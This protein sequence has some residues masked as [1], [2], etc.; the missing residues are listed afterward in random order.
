MSTP[1]TAVSAAGT[2][3]LP[4]RLWL[5]TGG[6]GGHVFPALALGVAA[7]E[8][9]WEVTVIGSQDGPEAGWTRD[10]GL[11][12]A[13]V[14]SG[15]LD[16]QRP[17]PRQL[18]RALRGV[19]AAVGL[20]RQAR[21]R[22]LVG[23]GGFAS[24]PGVAAARWLR[25]PYLLHETNAHPGLVTRWFAK[26]ARAVV[27]TQEVTA[28]A[29]PGARCLVLPLPVRER[30]PEPAAARAAFGLPE[31]ALVTLVMGGSQG[32]LYLN[33]TVPAVAEALQRERADLWVLHQTGHPW[34]ERV[35]QATDGRPRYL[36]LPFVDGSAAF[37]A[38]DMAITRAGYGTI[39]EAAF[40]RVPLLL[41]PLPSAA[42][43]HQRH[44][45]MAVAE[46]GAGL[47]V[48]QGDEAGLAAAWRS[49]LD[50][51]RRHATAE[52]A[53]RRS[54]EGGTARLLRAI[55]D[56]S[57]AGAAARAAVQPPSGSVL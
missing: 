11:A 15:K 13:G 9:G 53:G 27:L 28:K 30:R 24:L 6:T 55:E 57:E 31:D 21:P 36:T 26:G 44:N 48:A 14:P 3:S 10:A 19:I 18:W 50:E 35:R 16:R 41:V 47:W 7:K 38:A 37:A 5:A 20:L 2:A 23:F 56:M 33:D 39:A 17:D 54:P 34:L 12:F 51:G 40:H 45:A 4:R 49:L 1:G 8:A 29:L 25:L 22:L 52:A 32:S 43:D 46:E 42:E